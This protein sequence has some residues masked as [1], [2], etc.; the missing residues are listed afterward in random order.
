M[1]LFSFPSSL[2]FDPCYVENNRKT[3]S[4]NSLPNKVSHSAQG[5]ISGEILRSKLFLFTHGGFAV[6]WWKFREILCVVGVG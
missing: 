5:H 2:D 6:Y 4:L 1:Q 3:H